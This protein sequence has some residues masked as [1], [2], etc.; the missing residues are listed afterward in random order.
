MTIFIV[1]DLGAD[2]SFALGL[3]IAVFS[4]FI[5]MKSCSHLGGFDGRMMSHLH[6]FHS[7][8]KEE[9]LTNLPVDS[10]VPDKN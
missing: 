6:W 8:T 5:V 7:H 1:L 2:L 4:G 3:M 10:P 9:K